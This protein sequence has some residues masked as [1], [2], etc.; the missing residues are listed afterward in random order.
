MKLGVGAIT[1]VALTLAACS[2]SGSSRLS[3]RIVLDRSI[4]GVHLKE[5]RRDAERTLGRGVVVKTSDQKPPEPP[6]HGED[7]RYANSGVEVFYVS[8]TAAD[9]AEGRVIAVLTTSPRYRT[10]TGVHVGSSFADVRA[11]K[12][13][14]CYGTGM[15]QHGCYAVNT[16][17][18]GFDLTGD[19]RNDRVWR[20]T[21]SLGH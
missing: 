18:T 7:V 4:A 8:K 13:M 20:I 16:A 15:C 3:S 19:P 17:C 14:K 2:S 6:A 11:I 5:M 10:S 21:L 12:G 1:V 9:R